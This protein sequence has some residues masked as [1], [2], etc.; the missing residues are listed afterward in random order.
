MK[1]M[2]NANGLVIFIDNEDDRI[3][4]KNLRPEAKSGWNIHKEGG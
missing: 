1:P 4:F 2:E 3:R